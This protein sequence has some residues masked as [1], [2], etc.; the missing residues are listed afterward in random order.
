M[1]LV[2]S[3][4]GTSISTCFLHVSGPPTSLLNITQQTYFFILSSLKTMIILKCFFQWLFEH[5][6]KLLEHKNYLHIFFYIK[7]LFHAGSTGWQNLNVNINNIIFRQICL[8]VYWCER[9]TPSRDS[10]R[11]ETSSDTSC[12]RGQ[13]DSHW[14]STTFSKVRPFP[15]C[16]TLVAMTHTAWAGLGWCQCCH[17]LQ[18]I[19]LTTSNV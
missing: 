3:R 10:C 13:T 5:T 1:A 7:F 8:V 16:T 19:T 17:L 6:Q 14:Y 9:V 4:P 2:L 11:L 12:N 18:A 15:Q